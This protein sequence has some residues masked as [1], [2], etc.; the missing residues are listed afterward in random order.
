M[1]LEEALGLALMFTYKSYCFFTSALIS[2]LKDLNFALS[3]LMPVFLALA[4]VQFLLRIFLLLSGAI[5]A[6]EE[7]DLLFLKGYVLQQTPE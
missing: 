7:V 5:Q 1:Y 4:C 6:T 2:L 3:L